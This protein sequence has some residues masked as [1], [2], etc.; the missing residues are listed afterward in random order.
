MGPCT[1]CTEGN[2]IHFISISICSRQYLHFL[3]N[4]PEWSWECQK[5]VFN[6]KQ[7]N[8]TH[9]KNIGG[10]FLHRNLQGRL[11][12]GGRGAAGDTICCASPARAVPSHTGG[13]SPASGLGSG[14][15]ANFACGSEARA[16]A[17]SGGDYDDLSPAGSVSNNAAQ[18]VAGHGALPGRLAPT[19]PH[20]GCSGRWVRHIG[21]SKIK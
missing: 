11:E 15:S 18:V 2:H 19:C 9:S 12:A 21:R 20:Q 4:F 14:P 13:R 7:E 1:A 16:A 5:G 6:I 17:R 10:L 3:K 8:H